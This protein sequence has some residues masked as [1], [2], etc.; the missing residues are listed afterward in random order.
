LQTYLS[1]SSSHTPIAQILASTLPRA[2]AMNLP[3]ISPSQYESSFSKEKLESVTAALKKL[4]PVEGLKEALE[5]LKKGG[6]QVWA[7]SNG[8]FYASVLRR[9]GVVVDTRLT[10]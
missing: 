5:I 8:R 3:S 7:V 4:T 10:C 2:L 6:V 9:I 1:L